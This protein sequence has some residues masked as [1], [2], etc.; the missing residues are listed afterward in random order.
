V[1]EVEVKG[2]AI[3]VDTTAITILSNLN[4]LR[5][6]NHH[7][8]I[9]I[10]ILISSLTYNMGGTKDQVTRKIITAKTMDKNSSQILGSRKKK[11]TKPRLSNL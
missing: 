2:A 6:T 9:S 8:K 10:I 7:T 11:K 3:E 5:D 1:I 4:K